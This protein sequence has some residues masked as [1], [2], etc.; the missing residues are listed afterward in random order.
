[1]QLAVDDKTVAYVDLVAALES[2]SAG[3]SAAAPTWDRLDGRKRKLIDDALEGAEQE[4]AERVR[5]ALLEAERAGLKARFVAFVMGHISPEYFRTEAKGVVLPIRGADLER[6]VKLGYDVRSRNVHVLDELPP[7]TWVVGEKADTVSPRDMGTMLSLQGLAR[8]ARHVVKNYVDRAPAEIDPDFNWRASL[9][10]QVQVRLAP[11]YWVWQ[12]DAFDQQSADRYFSGFLDHVIS[13]D[14]GI[15]DIRPVL[16]RIEQLLGGTA[17]G[18]AKDSMVGIYALWHRM[19]PPRD[20]RPDGAAV[21]A[22]Y[23]D[24]LQ[25]VGMRAFAV[26][27]LTNQVPDWTEEEWVALAT[28][29]RA[30]RS[31][32]RHLELPAGLDAAVQ[33]FA[34]EA[35]N[36]SGGDGESPKV[37]QLRCGRTTRQSGTDGLG[38]R[39]GQRRHHRG[40]H[41][42][43]RPWWRHVRRSGASRGRGRG[44]RGI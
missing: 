28:D 34:A 7:E 31:K 42:R 14:E 32:R 41:D 9:P 33:M 20:H 12:A 4:V 17:D 10:G 35:L 13:S 38:R 44:D 5:Q 21:L 27:F 19:L 8:L 6:A 15:T 39:A 26:G 2:L 30:E 24:V 36:E 43:P 16:E 37:R 23:E 29:R 25:S 40:R 1:M 3:T 18:V 11:Q 22:R